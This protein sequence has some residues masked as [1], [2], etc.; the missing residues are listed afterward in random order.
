MN[1]VE[2]LAQLRKLLGGLPQ[3]DI[4]KSV[5][6]YSEMIDDCMEDGMTETEAVA[7]LGAIEDIV[8]HIRSNSEQQSDNPAVE[9]DH[10]N[11]Q[12]QSGK[13]KLSGAEIALIIITSPLWLGIVMGLVGV[14]FGLWGAVIGLYAAAGSLAFVCIAGIISAPFTQVGIASIIMQVGLSLICGGISIPAFFG[15]NLISKGLVK[16]VKVIINAVRSLF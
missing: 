11:S 2:F 16:L 5:E 8:M 4:E 1:K 12:Q 15:I 7:S 9:P 14:Y 3:E 13:H 6:F 10:T